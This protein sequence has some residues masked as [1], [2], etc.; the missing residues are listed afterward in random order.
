MAC[1]KGFEN[2]TENFK[3]K[4]AKSAFNAILAENFIQCMSTVLSFSLTNFQYLL[5]SNVHK[6]A[7]LQGFCKPLVF[8]RFTVFQ[9]QVHL[10]INF[11]DI[12]EV[13]SNGKSANQTL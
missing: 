3:S 8:D 7:Y 9:L 11:T 10:H 4:D 13:L 12:V 1:T 2:F 5:S 6:R